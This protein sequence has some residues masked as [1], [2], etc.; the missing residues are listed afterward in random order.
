M[1]LWDLCARIRTY[2]CTGEG[3]SET[4]QVFGSGSEFS[5]AWR[6]ALWSRSKPR[7]GGTFVRMGKKDEGL[8]REAHWQP[9]CKKYRGVPQ[10]G[11]KYR[12]VPQGCKKYR[13]VPQ[14]GKN[15]RFCEVLRRANFQLDLRDQ[16]L[17]RNSL[18]GWADVRRK[19]VRKARNS[20]KN[21]QLSIRIEPSELRLNRGFHHPPRT[22]HRLRRLVSAT[23]PPHVEATFRRFRRHR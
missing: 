16:G 12:G 14:G 18:T 5:R 17:C 1:G 11:K 21:C 10:G 2:A 19:R 6:K 9:C 7:V 15:I 4:Y 8:E 20:G 3:G 23:T 22:A 13:G